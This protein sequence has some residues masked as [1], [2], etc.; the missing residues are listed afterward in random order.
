MFHNARAFNE[1]HV[2]GWET[3]VVTDAYRMFG[4]SRGGAVG[5]EV[6]R[7]M[8]DPLGWGA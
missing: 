8:E 4:K 6:T 2:F 7:S 1:Q 3:G 5:G